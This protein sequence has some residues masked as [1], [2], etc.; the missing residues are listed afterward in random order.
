[1]RDSDAKRRLRGQALYR[2][3]GVADRH[4]RKKYQECERKT[5]DGVPTRLLT[6]DEIAEWRLRVQRILDPES[7]TVLVPVR[8]AVV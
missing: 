8:R 4:R 2:Y 5:I 3:A 1:M 6:A 7:V